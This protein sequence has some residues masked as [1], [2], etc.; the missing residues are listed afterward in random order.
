MSSKI[1]RPP[2]SRRL[3]QTESK[4]RCI[5]VCVVSWEAPCCRVGVPPQRNHCVFWQPRWMGTVHACG[6]MR[7]SAASISHTS[8]ISGLQWA[9]L[10]KECMHVGG[11]FVFVQNGLPSCFTVVMTDTPNSDLW[12]RRRQDSTK[13][14]TCRHTEKHNSHPTTDTHTTNKSTYAHPSR[15]IRSHTRKCRCK[16]APAPGR[17]K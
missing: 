10:Q 6:F 16:H 13:T 9:F 5:C 3:G 11:C 2:L 4:R 12:R 15:Y 14:H 8:P 17:T 7:V 1:Q